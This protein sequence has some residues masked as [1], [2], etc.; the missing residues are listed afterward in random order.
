MKLTSYARLLAYAGLA[1]LLSNLAYG[2]AFSDSVSN[3]FMAIN[4]FFESNQYEAYASIMDFMFFSLL[5][6]SVYLIGVRYGL[7]QAAKPEKA[8]AILLGILTAFLLVSSGFSIGKLVPYAGWL[9][10]FLLF[11]V[12]WLA[13][14]GVK[15]KFYR[16]VLALLVVL[17]IVALMNGYF[18][19]LAIR[20]EEAVE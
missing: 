11:L 8:I 12:V 17:L 19:D 9:M 13:L 2:S 3:G 15:N 14:K 1:A 6:I 4:D 16:L 7:R 5:F 20:P 10:F 18:E